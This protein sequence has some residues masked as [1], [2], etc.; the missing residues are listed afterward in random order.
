MK[1]WKTIAIYEERYS[2]S[3]LESLLAR[4]ETI[5]SNQELLLE[6]NIGNLED[7]GI[8]SD[9]EVIDIENLETQK[10]DKPHVDEDEALDEHEDEEAEEYADIL[11]EHEDEEQDKEI[12]ELRDY[13][14][15]Q[16]RRDDDIYE[17]VERLGSEEYDRDKKEMKTELSKTITANFRTMSR[18][19]IPHFVTDDMKNGGITEPRIAEFVRTELKSVV[20]A[21]DIGLVFTKRDELRYCAFVIVLLLPITY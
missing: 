21:Y 7:E 16:Q 10:E 18:I 3:R 14:S 20:K 13:R 12:E 4:Q 17:E 11:D 1:K 6:I 5:S 2:D 9:T 15:E 19:F 8:S